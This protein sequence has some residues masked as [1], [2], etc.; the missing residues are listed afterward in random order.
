MFDLSE[1]D[2]ECL[3]YFVSKLERN[4][5]FIGDGFS[6]GG[7][8][9]EFRMKLDEHNKEIQQAIQKWFNKDGK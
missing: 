8:C 6:V 2:F 1:S 3:K 4:R 5:H 7:A 9:A